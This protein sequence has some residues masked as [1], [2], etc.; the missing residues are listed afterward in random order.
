MLQVHRLLQ[1]IKRAFFHGSYSF[2][3]RTVGRQQQH[4]YRRIRLLRLTQNVQPRSP[5]HLQVGNHQQISSRTYLLDRG[6]AVRRFV[7]GVARALQCLSQH[8]AQFG[9]VFNEEERFHLF[10]FYH[11]SG[12]RQ[13]TTR[14]TCAEKGS[15][16]SG[17]KLS[18]AAVTGETS[19]LRHQI[20]Y[21]TSL[22]EGLS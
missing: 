3:Y 14:D 5:R 7:H 6:C 15:T 11:E 12:C 19:S 17:R 8:S 9:L 21:S 10:R 1:K 16:R 2:F 13:G 22:E 4:R 20:R 18:F